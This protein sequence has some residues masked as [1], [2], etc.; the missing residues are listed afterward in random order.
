MSNLNKNHTSNAVDLIKVPLEKSF[1]MWYHINKE[2][3]VWPLIRLICKII[4]IQTR[5]KVKL[6]NIFIKKV[7]TSAPVSCIIW[8]VITL[9]I[10]PIRCIFSHWLKYKK[11]KR[12]VLKMKIAKKALAVVMALAMVACL[13][14]MAFAAGSTFKVVTSDV[15]DGVVTVEIYAQNATGLASADLE[16]QYDDSV[17]SVKGAI[18]PGDIFN[19]Y[20]SS[21]GETSIFSGNNKLNP[22][23]LAF[24]MES[25]MDSKADFDQKAEDNDVSGVS[26]DPANVLICTIKFAVKEGATGDTT[27]KLTGAYKDGDEVE[28]AV[29]TSAKI[30]LSAAKPDTTEPVT[31][32]VDPKPVEEPSDK[33][34]PG[35]GDKTTGDNMALAAA[36]AVVLLAGAAFVISKKRK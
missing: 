10:A 28:T 27:L 31:E 7:L 14:A 6:E 35:T 9:V 22:I 23:P 17:L 1:K 12:K 2:K 24:A 15:K 36:G 18:K 8:S 11:E 3:A 21:F 4:I 5:S 29:D 34:N 13:S 26:Y 19:V 30:E 33:T 32:K 20:T 25:I 16:L